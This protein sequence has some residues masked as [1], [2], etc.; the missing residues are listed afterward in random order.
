MKNFMDR[1]HYTRKIWDLILNRLFHYQEE[2]VPDDFGILI[3]PTNIE[4]HLEKIR[5]AQELWAKNN[6]K[7]IQIIE[8]L[9]SQVCSKNSCRENAAR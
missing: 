6:P 9:K 4:S 8:E 1:G 5:A 2:K 7:M 3:T